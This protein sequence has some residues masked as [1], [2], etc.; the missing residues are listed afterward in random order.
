MS[1]S[2]SK[3]SD[4]ELNIIDKD[5]LLNLLKHE[6]FVVTSEISLYEFLKKWMR[7]DLA[8][9]GYQ[10]LNTKSFCLTKEMSEPYQDI[11]MNLRLNSLLSCPD[12]VHQIFED[13]II[14]SEVL[15]QVL[16]K[17]YTPLISNNKLLA[18]DDKNK[19][20]FAKRISSSRDV[21]ITTGFFFHGVALKYRFNSNRVSIERLGAMNLRSKCLLMN[22]D[23]ISVRTLVTLYGP[24]KNGRCISEESPLTAIDL[25]IE[26]ER[27]IHNWRKPVAFP[28]IIFV[29]LH[30]SCGSDV[31]DISQN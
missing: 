21:E 25:Y 6:S 10:G 11:F 1:L 31:V 14:S 2:S 8:R 17:M 16:F 12:K 24:A 28:S 26:R 18:Q 29:E 20:R 7:R 5:L 3:L 27:L 4:D 19:F 13:R 30:I 9:K 15:F 22:Y 23:H